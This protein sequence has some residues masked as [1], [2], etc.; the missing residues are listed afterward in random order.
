[1]LFSKIRVDFLDADEGA[2]LECFFD[3]RRKKFLKQFEIAMDDDS[4]TGPWDRS[5]GLLEIS[6]IMEKT[7]QLLQRINGWSFMDDDRQRYIDVLFTATSLVRGYHLGRYEYPQNAFISLSGIGVG[8]AESPTMASYPR[9][10]CC[11]LPNLS[12]HRRCAW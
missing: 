10:S 11:G 4:E 1:V 3:D 7:G 6:E 5:V 8:R 9:T 2:D 12:F